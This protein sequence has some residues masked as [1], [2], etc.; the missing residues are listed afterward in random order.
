M[1]INYSTCFI[2]NLLAAL[3]KITTCN[4]DGPEGFKLTILLEEVG[5][6]KEWTL[7][8]CLAHWSIRADEAGWGLARDLLNIYGFV[9]IDFIKVSDVQHLVFTEF[10]FPGL[11]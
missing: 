7:F 6:N 5:V 9:G 8:T 2:F 4:L 11:Y 10:F 3:L 1:F